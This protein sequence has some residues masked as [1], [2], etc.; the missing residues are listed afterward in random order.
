MVEHPADDLHRLLDRRLG[1]ERAAEVEAHVAG[2]ARCRRE[3]EAA[4]GVKTALREHL[5][6]VA[7]PD[8]L[9]ARLRAVARGAAPR[10]RPFGR[11]RPAA[12]AAAL[13]LA[14]VLLIVVT[15]GAERAA[16]I[17]PTVAA[18]YAA[19]RS[20]IMEIRRPTF[21]PEELLRFFQEERVPFATPV[22]LFDGMGYRLA[23]G[24]VIRDD[25]RVRALFAYEGV[26]G[27]RMLCEMY[28][29][30]TAE[31][32]D[33][34]EVRTLDDIDFYVYRLG[35]LTL[36]FW[37]DGPVVCV[38]IADGDPEQVIIFAHAKATEV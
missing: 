10:R 18:D 32:T 1:A 24:S 28:D 4:R 6:Q 33:P 26:D 15:R 36:V 20:G 8:A 2:C 25:G 12:A 34:T 7:T 27:G 31:L 14:A 22:F 5:P 3:L 35:D 17:V 16:D 30:T 38:L 13:A 11:R 9:A 37:Q 29:G 23:G 19:Y 21:V